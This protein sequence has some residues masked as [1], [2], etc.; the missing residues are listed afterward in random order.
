MAEIRVGITG[1]GGRMG[2]MLVAELREAPGLVLAG[3]S[4]SLGSALLGRDIG[5][6]AGIGPVGLAVGPDAAALVRASDV[7]IDFTAPAAAT[8][9]ARL[10]AE[11]QVAQVG[12]NQPAAAG[13]VIED[14]VEL[15]AGKGRVIVSQ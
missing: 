1:C 11:H 10:A 14:L 12:A 3:G 9:H 5:E 4:E 13:Q 8:A 15:F 7:V 6:L 2:R